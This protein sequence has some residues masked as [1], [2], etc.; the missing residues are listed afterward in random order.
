MLSADGLYGKNP[1]DIVDD[2]I[3]M[4]IAGSKT[5]QTTVTNFITHM[6]HRPDLRAKVDAEV[7]PILNKCKDDFMGLMTTEVIEDLDYLRMCYQEVL[8]YDS[9]IPTSSTSCFSKDVT[10]GGIHFK[11]NTPIFIAMAEMHRDPTEW[12]EPDTFNPDRFDPQSK[13]FKRAD[14]SNRNSLAFNP[15]LGGKRVCLGKTFAETTLKLVLPL[16]LHHF[17]FEFANDEHK[18]KRPHYEIGGTTAIPI[19]IN[20]ITKN[21]VN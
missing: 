19:P 13:W 16:Y 6:L 17:D 8:R 18:V 3:I 5:V 21:K 4:F 11:K 14:G 1:N 15:F 20:F 7:N 2:V 10:I 9:P 12:Q